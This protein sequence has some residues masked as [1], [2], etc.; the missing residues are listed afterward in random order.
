M[1]FSVVI[2]YIILSISFLIA[3]ATLLD[4]YIDILNL[5][6]FIFK[7]KPQEKFEIT[8]C[9][10][11]TPCSPCNFTAILKNVGE[12]T[13]ELNY[14]T[15]VFDGKIY[16]Y[17]ASSKYLFP[18]ENESITILNVTPTN[19][20]LRIVTKKGSSSYFNCKIL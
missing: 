19:L 5:S 3:T 4:T 13:I 8:D 17:I 18:L 12:K 1:G 11:I 2:A 10:N 14:L 7:E 16:E 15:V 20:R 9:Y 6:E